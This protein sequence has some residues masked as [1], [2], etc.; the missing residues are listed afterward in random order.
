MI[1]QFTL[2]TQLYDYAVFHGVSHVRY[3]LT[4]LR[5]ASFLAWFPRVMRALNTSISFAQSFLETWERGRGQLNSKIVEVCIRSLGDEVLHVRE[6]C[7]YSPSCLG[8]HIE[9]WEDLDCFSFGKRG[10]LMAW[11]TSRFTCTI[12]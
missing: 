1:P 10:S 3:L 9:S 2:Q 7:K 6:L 12:S 8:H 11:I 4:K 5:T